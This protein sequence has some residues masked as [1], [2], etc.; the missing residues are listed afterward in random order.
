M[1]CGAS[2][3]DLRRLSGCFTKD[4]LFATVLYEPILV[5]SFILMAQRLAIFARKPA[6]PFLPS[7]E[8]VVLSAGLN[9]ALPSRLSEF[10]KPAILKNRVGIPF[11]EGLGAVILERITDLLIVFGL[12]IS[13]VGFLCIDLN[14]KWI[15][16]VFISLILGL[17]SL[18]YLEAGILKV[19][20][21]LPLRNWKDF[22]SRIITHAVCNVRQG[23]I[24]TGGS[25]GL[26]AW[27]FS[28]A[29]VFVYFDYVGR[30][31][32]GL[33]GSMAVFVATSLANCIPGLPGA[34]G[35]YEAATTVVLM[36]YGYGLEESIALALALHV[37]QFFLVLLMSGAILIR[38]Q[39]DILALLKDIK[40]SSLDMMRISK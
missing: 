40:A 28:A 4:I 31:P 24:Y 23:R 11:S 2:F 14:W 10:V 15:V 30:I 9:F 13:T 33:Q 35:T 26:G 20:G 16:G 8:S 39:I 7:L 6:A 25:F 36:R 17:A 38:G 29:S 19:I 34:I 21:L 37:G 32:I 18:P 5:I 3:L 22:L 27:A 1:C 12:A